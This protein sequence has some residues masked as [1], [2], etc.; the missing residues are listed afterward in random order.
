MRLIVVVACGAAAVAHAATSEGQ[1]P[2]E[3][4]APPAASAPA[5]PAANE[6]APAISEASGATSEETWVSTSG[7]GLLSLPDTRT[8]AK[9][10]LDLGFAFDNQDRDPVRL[11]VA[12][13]SIA[14]NYG[15]R[16]NV[17]TYGHV[18][19]SREV[20]VGDRP[21]AVAQGARNAYLT[22]IGAGAAVPYI[23]DRSQ[24]AVFTPADG[25]H[26]PEGARVLPSFYTVGSHDRIASLLV[27]G[28]SFG[29]APR[30]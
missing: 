13:Y 15:I 10:H 11:D 2:G 19:V 20:I 8:L 7:S 16:S 22:A 1:T 4:P 3:A 30:P 18:V 21:S 14:W 25:P 28:W 17:E 27:L 29:R 23:R 12:D 24:I 26:L 9:K 6:A 5:P